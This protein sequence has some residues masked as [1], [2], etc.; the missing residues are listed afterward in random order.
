MI[1]AQISD[2]HIL[3][4]SSDDALGAKRA[5]NLR[6]CVADINRQGV[7][8]VIHTGD[9]VHHG[10]ADEYALLSEI[11]SE[12]RPPLF[13]TPG[14]RDRH[15]GIHSAFNDLRY[16]PGSGDLLHY[17]I[18]DYPVRLVALDSVSAGERKGVFCAQRQ[19]WLEDT[20]AHEPKRPTLL[21]IHHPPFDVGDHYVG[22]YRQMQDA[23]DLAA[24]VSRHPQVKR[25]LCGHVHRFHS[26][27]WA[28]TIATIMPSVAVDLRKDVDA[29]L[30]DTPLY[31]LHR[32]SQGDGLTSQM[33]VVSDH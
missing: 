10:S 12:L 30:E 9:C 4:K 8:V 23:K 33:R 18:E 26:E 15:D 29:A 20:L 7:D 2:T 24:V 3:A 1:I 13:L 14:N 22:G 25:L 21:F 11:L 16:L 28:G 17:A 19:A 27:S 5:D 31:V 6:R 32:W